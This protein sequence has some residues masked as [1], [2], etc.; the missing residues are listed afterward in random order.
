MAPRSINQVF[1]DSPQYY[2]EVLDDL[3][4]CRLVVKI[5]CLNPIRS[6]K[7]RGAELVLSGIAPGSRVVCA[8][9]GNF[10]QAMAWASRARGV[11]LIVYASVNANPLKLERMRALGA[12]VRL[13]GDDFDAAKLEAKRVAAESGVRMV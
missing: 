10:G 12:D 4:Q 1:L 13:H 3:L 11:A 6:F 5:E 8:S 7:G 2:A 9:A